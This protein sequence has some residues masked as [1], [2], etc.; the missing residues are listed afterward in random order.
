M[1]DGKTTE[2]GNVIIF[3]DDEKDVGGGIR[4]T[5]VGVGD[6]GAVGGVRVWFNCG[7]RKGHLETDDTVLYFFT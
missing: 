1:S 6:V 2:D 5:D 7:G 4:M 3:L